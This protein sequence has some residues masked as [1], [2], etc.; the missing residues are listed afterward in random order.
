M[1]YLKET[2]RELVKYY[3]NVDGVDWDVLDSMIRN[4]GIALAV[5]TVNEQTENEEENEV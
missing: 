4:L 1:S 2:A 3:N 5:D